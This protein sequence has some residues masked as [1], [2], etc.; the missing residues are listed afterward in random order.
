MTPTARTLLEL[1]KRGCIADV[2]ERR[3]ARTFI[4]K[5]LFGVIDVVALEPGR[6][7][8]LGVQA[9]ST[10]NARARVK[11]ILDEPRALSWLGAGNRLE[12]WGFAKRGKRGKPK[13]WVLKVTPI[14][15]HL[16]VTP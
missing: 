13:R 16:W 10:S 4:T 5:D 11:K 12:V 3:L 2:V 6:Q 14:T 8:V 7:G 1:R 15:E 9:T